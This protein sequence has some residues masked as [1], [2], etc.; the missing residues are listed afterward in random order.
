MYT[1]SRQLVSPDDVL[2][3][4][5]HTP[6][7]TCLPVA[8]VCNR[9]EKHDTDSKA[10][11][12]CAVSVQNMR[13]PNTQRDL[14]LLCVRAIAQDHFENLSR[15]LTNFMSVEVLVSQQFI[16]DFVIKHSTRMSTESS[17]SNIAV[18]CAEHACQ[19]PYCKNPAKVKSKYRMHAKYEL[20]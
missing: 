4:N 14:T 3:S 12:V 5:T 7:C 15:N 2:T 10:S 6:H 19:R 20:N 8:S 18:K 11:A 1:C 13:L 16:H 9:F 17:A